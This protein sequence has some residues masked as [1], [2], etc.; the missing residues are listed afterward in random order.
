M[1]DAF[2]VGERDDAGAVRHDLSMDE[3]KENIMDRLGTVCLRVRVLLVTRGESNGSFPLIRGCCHGI[4]IIFVLTGTLVELTIS[5]STERTR[6]SLE[7]IPT[8][9]RSGKYDH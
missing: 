5:D 4:L 8:A 7:E 2:R 1:L 9:I 6:T 3:E